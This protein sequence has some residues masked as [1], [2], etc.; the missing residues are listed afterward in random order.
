[1]LPLHLSSII[2]RAYYYYKE[3]EQE[4]TKKQVRPL[5]RLSRVHR[6]FL[7]RNFLTFP[8]RKINKL[9]NSGHVIP[10]K[11]EFLLTEISL[12]YNIIAYQNKNRT[13]LETQLKQD[14]LR[15][16]INLNCRN[17]L[18]QTNIF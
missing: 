18:L 13:I 6:Y 3:Y 12:F 2:V 8:R 10:I 7:H 4:K 17:K 5:R 9:C 14:Y 1:M 16:N 11:M 15:K